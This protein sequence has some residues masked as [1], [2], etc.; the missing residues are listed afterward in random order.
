MLISVHSYYSL[1][2]GTI[3]VEPLVDLLLAA[4]YTSAALTDIN[5]TTGSLAFLKCASAKG[6]AAQVG[7]EF[8]NGDRLLYIGLA[9]NQEGFRE[10]NELLTQCNLTGTPLPEI[11]PVFNAVYVIYPYGQCEIGDLR[12]NEYIGVKQAH[13]N[14]LW[15][16]GTKHQS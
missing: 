4:G 12:D 3:G 7:V 5:N 8:R 10:L 2:Y 16:G 14:K 9:R 15:Q 6:L 13:L 11:A 1:R